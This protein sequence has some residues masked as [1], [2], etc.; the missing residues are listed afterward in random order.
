MGAVCNNN[1]ASTIGPQHPMLTPTAKETVLVANTPTFLLD[2][3][4]R[5]SAVQYVLASMKPPEIVNCLQSRLDNPLTDATKLVILYVLLVA[6]SATDPA[7]QETWR[8]INALDL[9]HLE[10]GEVLKRLIRADAIPTT[11]S[12]IIFP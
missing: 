3:L 5:D 7:D 2:R 11:V 6:L 1:L 4:R 10:W 9:S 12:S 8:R